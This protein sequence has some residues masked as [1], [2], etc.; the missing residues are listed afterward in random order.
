MGVLCRQ[1]FCVAEAL[2][3]NFSVGDG[4]FFLLRIAPSPSQF[5]TTGCQSAGLP[6]LMLFRRHI[7]GNKFYG[8]LWKGGMER[9][10]WERRAVNVAMRKVL[11][12]T[13]K[14]IR[15]KILFI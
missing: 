14:Q 6:A 8:A 7:R 5:L 12:H 15:N 11:D 2:K 3:K 9:L 1:L 13:R 4:A 10:Y